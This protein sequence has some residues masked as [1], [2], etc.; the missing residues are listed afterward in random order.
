MTPCSLVYGHQRFV[1]PCCLYLRGR[2]SGGT[3]VTT[4]KMEIKDSSET[5]VSTYQTTLRHIHTRIW[6][7]KMCQQ[8]RLRVSEN[9]V[10][11]RIF[12]PKRDELTREWKKLRNEE[13]NNLYS[14]LNIVRV[15]KSRRMRWAGH[16]A[17]MGVLVGKP[18]GKRPLGSPRRR[19]ENK[20]NL[21]I[22]KWDV[23]AWTGLSWLR[24]GTGCG[25]LWVWQWTFGFDKM[26]GISWL[27]E[28]RL[29]SQEGFCTT[30]WVISK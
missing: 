15:I 3:V 20:I 29:V 9:R 2:K 6:S 16:V 27:M 12:G 8:L 24:I 26:R 19:R 5:S 25:H 1:G 10:L 7:I 17:R 21:D 11:R 30:E 28:N 22:Q 4:V 14:S 18:D 23:R 13:L